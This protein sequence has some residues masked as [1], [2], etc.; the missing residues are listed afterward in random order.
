MRAGGIRVHPGT[1]SRRPRRPKRTHKSAIR[2]PF[3]AVAHA[4]GSPLPPS[5]IYLIRPGRRHGNSQH[6]LTPPTTPA[7]YLYLN[8]MHYLYLNT[9]DAP[10]APWPSAIADGRPTPLGP[11]PSL[12]M[13][14]PCP[15]ALGHRRLLPPIARPCCS[16]C[17]VCSE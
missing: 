9:V 16:R 4:D 15:S 10:H 7:G 11:R 6:P 8:T 1:H 14:A 2:A 12:Q 17:T 3:S 13:D 5:P